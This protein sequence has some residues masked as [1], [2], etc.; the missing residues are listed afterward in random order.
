VQGRRA[1]ARPQG[2]GE[3]LDV[4]EGDVVRPQARV[5][6][7]EEDV[8]TLALDRLGGQAGRDVG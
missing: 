8:R 1:C 6:F 4:P 2:D 3:V 5:V 7:G